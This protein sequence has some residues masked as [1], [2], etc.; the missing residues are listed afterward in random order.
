[1]LRDDILSF[2]GYEA[3][4]S[5]AGRRDVFLLSTRWKRNAAVSSGH[6]AEEKRE[7]RSS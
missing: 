7:E 1:M 2:S 4:R 5:G 3:G 6:E